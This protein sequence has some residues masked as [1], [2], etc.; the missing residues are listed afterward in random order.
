MPRA[1]TWSWYDPRLWFSIPIVPESHWATILVK[2]LLR[3]A[4]G[5]TFLKSAAY[6][7]NAATFLGSLTV[8]FAPL[9]SQKDVIPDWPY[10]ASSACAMEP[11]PP[12]MVYPNSFF[13]ASVSFFAASKNVSQVAGSSREAFL[14]RSVR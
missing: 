1:F 12:R 5:V 3:S 8:V 13:P 6:F 7:S 9:A 11:A 2:S 14:N 4:A 10:M